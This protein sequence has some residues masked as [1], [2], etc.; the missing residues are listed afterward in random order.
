MATDTAREDQARR[1]ETARSA[2]AGVERPCGGALTLSDLP[3]PDTKRW[4]I[5]RK[6]AII[7]AIRGGLLSLEEA[8]SRYNLSPAEILSWQH[9]ID[10][11]GI[12][13]LRT[14]WTQVYL[15]RRPNIKYATVVERSLAERG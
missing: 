8:C 4:V 9:R 6:A 11:F 7:D 5:R 15:G 12:A 2:L 1:H 14:T 3:L 13:G 10:R